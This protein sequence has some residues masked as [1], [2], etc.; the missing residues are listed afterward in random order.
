MKSIKFF[1]ILFFSLLLINSAQASTI[2]GGD[3]VDQASADHILDII[4]LIDISGSMYD[5]INTIGNNA[6]SVI[7]NLECPDCDV[8]VRATFAGINGTYGSVFNQA[9]SGPNVNHVEDNGGAAL[10]AI[11]SVAGTWWTKD[12]AVGQDYY[13]A[14]VTIGDEGTENGQPVSQADWDIAYAANQAAAA[15][16]NTFLF[17]W[18][19][20]DPYSGVIDLFQTMAE[21]GTGGGYTFDSTGGAYVRT[22][23]NDGAEVA[24]ALETI[25]C[26]AG[27]GG[28]ENPVPE[29][30]TMLLFGIGLLGLAG[31]NRKK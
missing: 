1:F 16:S 6:Q 23:T 29:P 24:T 5:D 13:R 11:N 10:D 4:F 17:S 8:W 31:V 18:V 27:S 28:T 3:A 20:D 15:L 22:M 30:A 12:A 14:V 26:T 2:V 25:I 7:Q 19:T 9:F 21:G